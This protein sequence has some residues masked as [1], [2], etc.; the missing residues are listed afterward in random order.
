MAY[1]DMISW[2]LEKIDIPTRSILN[3]QAVIIDSFRHEHIQVMYKLSPNPKFIYNAEFIAEFQIKEC[4]EADQTYP[5]LIKGWWR[6][7]SKFRADTQRIYAISSLNEYMVYVA[8]MLCKLFGKKNPC[9]FLAEWVPFLEEA[10]KGYSFNWD[11]ILSDNIAKKVSNYKDAR[12][13]GQPVAFYMSTYIMDVICFMTPLSLMNWSWNIT[14]LK[15]IHEYHSEMWEENAKKLFYK[16]CHFMVIPMH[17]MF[18][19]CDPPRISE[20][21]SKNLKPIADWFIE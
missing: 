2:A 5:D 4:T 9:H 18:F 10:S 21:V 19:G 13:R 11:K 14:C 8:M 1:N 3:D 15:P 17:K 20:T 7:P 6:S 16:I 12:S